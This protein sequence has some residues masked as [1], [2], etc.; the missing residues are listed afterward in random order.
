MV[1]LLH[2]E[3]LSSRS[4]PPPTAYLLSRNVRIEEDLSWTSS[5]NSPQREATRP[6]SSCLLRAPFGKEPQTGERDPPK[7]SQETLAAMV[8]ATRVQGALPSGWGGFWG[9]PCVCSDLARL[10]MALRQH[11]SPLPRRAAGAGVSASVRARSG[12]SSPAAESCRRS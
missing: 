12:S 3:S 11:L 10:A 8:G 9:Q 6:E 7:V 4:F 1:R 5:S 2:R